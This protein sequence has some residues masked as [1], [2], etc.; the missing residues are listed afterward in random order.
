MTSFRKLY[1][2][3]N[4]DVIAEGIYSNNKK[5]FDALFDDKN[6]ATDAI[7]KLIN[8]EYVNEYHGFFITVIYDED[9]R[10][11][12]GFVISYKQDQIPHNST[13]MALKDTE[14]FS[15]PLMLANRLFNRFKFN[16]M[17]DNY[18]INELYVLEEYRNKGHGTR[19]IKKSIQ[20]ARQYNA[21]NVVLDVEYGKDYLLNFFN[22]LGFKKQNKIFKRFMGNVP[23]YYKLEY[24]LER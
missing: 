12:E 17:K 24:K 13:F 5:V 21:D 20:K 23:G 10:K 8:S 3:D 19:L 11:I 2:N 15:I 6:K 22:K 1:K 18:I 16:L 9:P 14:D 7:I 4:M